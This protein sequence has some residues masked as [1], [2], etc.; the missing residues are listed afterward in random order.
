MEASRIISPSGHPYLS[1][2]V[3]PQKAEVVDEEFAAA[4][5]EDRAKRIPTPQGYQILCVV[6]EV[7][8]TYENGI[9]KAGTTVEHDEIMSLVL[10]VVKV[11]PNAYQDGTK[12]PYGPYCKEGDFVLVRALSGTRFKIEGQE[13][14]LINDDSVLATVD[15]P[16]GV[17]RV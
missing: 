13:F 15:D 14:R 1:Q 10:F 9:A 5:P 17:T 16:R 12:F 7:E 2:V 11:G 4:A 6:P 3:T 8:D